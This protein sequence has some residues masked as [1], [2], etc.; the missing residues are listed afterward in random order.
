MLVDQQPNLWI[1][2][3]FNQHVWEAPPV[4]LVA[5]FKDSDINVFAEEKVFQPLHESVLVRHNGIEPM[6]S[7]WKADM[8]PLA[9]MTH[10]ASGKP[11][12]S[13]SYWLFNIFYG[14][15]FTTIFDPL[16]NLQTRSF[17]FLDFGIIAGLDILPA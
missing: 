5:E 6:S 15:N 7:A 14:K 4:V 10:I 9:L 16:Q 3:P 2:N 11:I 17:V 13:A 12:I 8:L 1:I